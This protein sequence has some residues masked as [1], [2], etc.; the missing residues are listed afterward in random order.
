[1]T[2]DDDC[3]GVLSQTLSRKCGKEFVLAVA[4]DT[5]DAQ[6]LATF[7]FQRDVLEPNAVRVV[8][9][10]AEIIDHKAP[11]RG[12]ASGRRFHLLDGCTD[13]HAGG[14]GRGL[15]LRIAGRDLP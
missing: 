14:R 9:L 7:Q 11:Y 15:L 5:G 6:Y 4:G 12:L 8:R 10:Q 3:A 1:M 2:V 13:P